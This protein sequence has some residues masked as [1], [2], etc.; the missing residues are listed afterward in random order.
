M[1][2]NIFR[3]IRGGVRAIPSTPLKIFNGVRTVYGFFGVIPILRAFPTFGVNQKVKC[4]ALLPALHRSQT[5]KY[6]PSKC[7]NVGL[8]I[9]GDYL[10]YKGKRYPVTPLTGPDKM[11][12]FNVQGHMLY[13]INTAG[14]SNY[15]DFESKEEENKV[16][17]VAFDGSKCV[18]PVGKRNNRDVMLSSEHEVYPYSFSVCKYENKKTNLP[19]SLLMLPFNLAGLAIGCT[20]RTFGAILLGVARCCDNVSA[21]IAQRVDKKIIHTSSGVLPGRY[22]PYAATLFMFFL[23][24]VSNSLTCCSSF[25]RHSANFCESIIRFPSAITN[26]IHN[27]NMRCLP[28][29]AGMS[30][31]S[32]S[33]RLLCLGIR[34][35]GVNFVKTSLLCKARLGGDEKFLRSHVSGQYGFIVD[36]ERGIEEP[37]QEEQ[38]SQKKKISRRDLEAISRLGGELSEQIIC[39]TSEDINKELSKQKRTSAKTV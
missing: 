39:G 16:L 18:D 28:V 6:I 31:I 24:I 32:D 36:S 4:R 8:K 37:K 5:C 1:F 13:A 27:R 25:V 26:G 33:A 35:S 22:R 3:A 29:M 17:V 23:S 19:L 7:H 38:Q 9:E 11:P 14:L 12:I 34:D 10:I 20:G 21:Y 2:S 15:K 30:A